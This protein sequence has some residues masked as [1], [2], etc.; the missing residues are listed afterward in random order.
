M[1][2]LEWVECTDPTPM[3]DF[4][5]GRASDRKLRLFAC[6]CCRRVWDLMPNR[7]SRSAV[8]AGEQFADGLITV[9]QLRSVKDDCLDANWADDYSDES[10]APTWIAGNWLT[11]T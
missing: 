5:K 9:E 10:Q 7:R 8:E 1:S 6:A 11:L 3:L 2:E 4:L